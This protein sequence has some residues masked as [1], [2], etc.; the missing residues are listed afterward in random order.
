MVTAVWEG[1]KATGIGKV[2]V[3]ECFR[4]QLCDKKRPVTANIEV[5]PEGN[6]FKIVTIE[7]LP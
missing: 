4:E 2:L 3:P 7:P 5:E 1:K 6:A